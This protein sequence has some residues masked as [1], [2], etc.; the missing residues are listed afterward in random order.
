MWKLN[1]LLLSMLHM[2]S[3][4]FTIEQVKQDDILRLHKSR[5]NS[6]NHWVNNTK[7]LDYQTQIENGYTSK[8]IELFKPSY[9]KITLDNPADIAWMKRANIVCVQ[10]GKFTNLYAEE[11][12]ET[13]N[14]LE[15]TYSKIFDGTEYFVRAEN[16]SL[17]YGVNGVGPYTNI[18]QIIESIV[19]S[20]GSHTPIYFDT[21]HIHIYLIPWVKIKEPDEF[22]VFICKNQ[23]T[24]ISQ[25]NLYTVLY[26]TI[27]TSK[28]QSIVNYF[29]SEI[30][31]KITWMSSYTYDFAFVNGD[32]TKPYFIEPNSFGKEYAA[33]S[34]LFHWICD[35]DILYGNKLKTLEQIYFRYTIR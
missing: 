5:Y 1:L 2:K 13:S 3:Y 12:E 23:I 7:P 30:K 21:T 29:Y 28:L 17:K 25:Q 35:E 22:R 10:T 14:R 27:L 16:V 26:D 24:A 11:L 6:N 34:A 8:W 33:G 9:I 32:E 18:K 31:P 19:S 20:S 15:L 4:N